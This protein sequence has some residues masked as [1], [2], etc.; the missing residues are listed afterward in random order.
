MDVGERTSAPAPPAT[1]FI[2]PAFSGLRAASNCGAGAFAAGISSLDALEGSGH[3]LTGGADFSGTGSIDQP[4]PPEHTLGE[5]LQLD[6][7]ASTPVC[8]GGANAR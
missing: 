5:M 8:G 7:R 6:C 2:S 4:A 3:A 1:A